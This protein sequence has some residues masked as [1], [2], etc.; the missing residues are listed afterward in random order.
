MT[1]D[2]DRAVAVEARVRPAVEAR[3]A[4]LGLHWGAP[5]LLRVFK[6][7]SELELWLADASGRFVLFDTF[8]ICRSSGALGA[9]LREGDH[10]AP[11]GFYAVTPAA[12][13]PRSRYHL[14]FDLGFPNA[15]DRAHGRTGSYLMVHGGCVSVGCYAM[16]DDA[17]ETIY[18]VVA[19]AL[20]HGQPFV[21]VH[22]LPFRFDDSWQHA[23]RDSPWLAFW[24]NLA[25]GDALFR[26]GH[27]EPSVDVR[28]GRYVFR[29]GRSR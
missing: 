6:Q 20:G 4:T 14:S 28:D 2:T 23:H 12:L 22:A 16:G 8:A 21:P 18:T 24:M 7:S 15:F 25:E 13:N 3:L 29:Q 10:Q 19:A 27:R 1:A 9:K 17:I 11:E 5:A 26:R